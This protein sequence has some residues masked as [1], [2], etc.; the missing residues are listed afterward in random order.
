MNRMTPVITLTLAATITLSL[1]LCASSQA[2]A[3]YVTSG[4]ADPTTQGAVL[5]SEMLNPSPPPVF[6]PATPPT[7]ILSSGNDGEAYWRIKS[8]PYPGDSGGTYYQYFMETA[9]T[10]HA[11]GWTFTYRAKIIDAD[12]S[13][14]AYFAVVDAA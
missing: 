10:T 6:I 11:S 2:A 8:G 9:D 3:P 12:R 13:F 4:G 14:E 5:H 1:V 7:V